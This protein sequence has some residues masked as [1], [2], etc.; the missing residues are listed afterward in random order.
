[1]ARTAQADPPDTLAGRV[2]AG[3]LLWRVVAGSFRMVSQGA[4]ATLATGRR[5]DRAMGRIPLPPPD[6]ADDERVKTVLKSSRLVMWIDAAID[7]PARAWQSSAVRRWLQPTIDAVGAQSTA[8]QLRLLGWTL[9]VAAM[10]HIVLVLAFS[11]PVGWPTWLAWLVFIA[12]AMVVACWP[13][14]VV[15]AWR[16]SRFRRRMRGGRP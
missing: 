14:Q 2:A 16:D 5:L 9:I 11:E 1:M 3:S 15:T 10:T 4:R 13:A 6:P 8:D 7:L 12:A